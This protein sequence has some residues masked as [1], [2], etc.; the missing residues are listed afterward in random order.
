LGQEPAT[1]S[2]V[3]RDFSTYVSLATTFD[4]IAACIIISN[5]CLIKTEIIRDCTKI[6][7]P[8]KMK[9]HQEN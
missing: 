6:I 9:A 1:I 4:P 5:I 2:E 8:N 3:K 7:P